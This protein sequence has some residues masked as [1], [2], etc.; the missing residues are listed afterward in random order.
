MPVSGSRGH[1]RVGVSLPASKA[2]HWR[3]FTDWARSRCYDFSVLPLTLPNCQCQN[4]RFEPVVGSDLPFN[5]AEWAQVHLRVC[6]HLIDQ[7]GD[8]TPYFRAR[9]MILE[10]V[11]FAMHCGAGV[12][13]LP[14][15]SVEV[16]RKYNDPSIVDL[17]QLASRYVS[18]LATLPTETNT[19]FVVEVPLIF[20][21]GDRLRS[22][23]HWWRLVALQLGNTHNVQITLCLN[24][25][26]A[27]LG[28]IET[29]DRSDM[30]SLA[31]PEEPPPESLARWRSECLHSV[32]ILQEGVLENA[33]GF[34]VLRRLVKACVSDLMK[35][36]VPICIEPASLEKEDILSAKNAI[37]VF[38]DP[39][40]E[41]PGVEPSPPS[42]EFSSWRS[43]GIRFVTAV[44]DYIAFLYVSLPVM[45]ENE[46]G[47]VGFKDYL[48]A[49]LQPL[50]HNLEA[51]TYET[52]EL[53]P[54]KYDLYEKAAEELIPILRNQADV[55]RGVLSPLHI[56][57]CG[58]GRGPILNGVFKAIRRLQKTNVLR[59]DANFVFTVIEKNSE[60]VRT[61]KD[62]VRSDPETLWRNVE[63]I[64]SDMRQWH[65]PIAIDLLISEL[66]GSF[67]DN[68]SS[69]ECLMQLEQNLSTDIGVSIPSSYTS[70]LEPISCALVHRNVAE[71]GGLHQGHVV[72]LQ[73]FYC[74]SEEGP[75]PAFSFHHSRQEDMQGTDH[76]KNETR[77]ELQR[78]ICIEW[79]ARTAASCH[80]FAGYFSAQLSPSVICSTSPLDASEDMASWFPLFIPL[81][82]PVFVAAGQRVRIVI[83]RHT[84]NKK[85]WYEWN[86]LEPIITPVQNRGGFAWNVGLEID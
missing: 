24:A 66:L 26:E 52:L 36:G 7:L 49:P 81:E 2:E 20:L 41:P 4:S 55:L 8:A 65:P 9:Q 1:L 76:P 84:S 62:R 21:H 13:Y 28:G 56:S 75:T 34:P 60:A 57:Y 29:P 39:G 78:E 12:L 17:S 19:K 33:A 22:G 68:E 38:K 64:C 45:T 54:V 53:D 51:A 37:T 15:P 25:R 47:R 43:N 16:W 44:R 11:R 77:C 86:L 85:V 70:Y 10:Q 18:I 71:V 35:Q 59:S 63:V 82:T 23:W 73:S 79:S 32:R 3:D 6:Q 48:Q 42:A 40:S 74:F 80:G 30:L 61:L 31:A 5:S 58:A 46:K 69:P 14:S 67:G 50:A 83:R 72:D 27:L